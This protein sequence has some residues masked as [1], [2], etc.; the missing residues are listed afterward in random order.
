MKPIDFDNLFD[1]YLNDYLSQVL[2]K[3]KPDE[4]EKKIPVK[5]I[6]WLTTE[7]DVLDGKTPKDFIENLRA[8]GAFSAYL[9]SYVDND[10]EISSIVAESC[11]AEDIPT[12]IDIVKNYPEYAC[13]A[14]AIIKDIKSTQADKVI[15]DIVL[16]PESE[17]ALVDIAVEMLSDGTHPGIVD[18]ILA[19][20][21]DMDDLTQRN[22][23]DILYRYPGNNRIYE[24]IVRL[25]RR[26][27]ELKHIY[28]AY[29]GSYGNPDAID[30]LLDYADNTI[31]DYYEFMELRNAVERLGGEMPQKEY[32]V[33]KR[34]QNEVVG[35]I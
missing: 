5:Y 18:D 16:N 33:I 6:E 20:I 31:M 10:M 7:L 9:K 24:W 13:P 17:P 29:L 15:L 30:L 19:V 3:V 1:E 32:Q 8:T 28:C 25:W 26:E 12:L 27:I 34:G 22:L 14:C 21:D 35:T 2:G 23:V 11:T 4:I